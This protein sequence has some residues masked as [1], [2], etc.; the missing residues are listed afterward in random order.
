MRLSA[1]KIRFGSILILVVVS[2][3]GAFARAADNDPPF[4]T[5]TEKQ[6]VLTRILQIV[7][8]SYVDTTITT[9]KLF[10]GAI[11]GAIKT[12]DPHSSYMPPDVADA[13]DEKIRGDFEGI[14]ITFTMLDDTITVIEV[15]E[16]GPSELA[17]L[18]PRDRIVT[19]DGIDVIGVATDSVKVLLRG[20]RASRVTV[21]V[22]RPGVPLELP[23]VIVRDTILLNSVSHAYM[24]DETTGYIAIS[25]F[26]TNTH[27]D[28]EKSL[29]DLS[30]AGMRQLVLDMRNNSGGSLSAAVG[31]VNHFVPGGVI[32][33]TRGK[34]PQDNLVRHADGY[35]AYPDVPMIV[36][37]NHRSA[38]ASEVVAG[39]LQDHDR[40]L[41]VGRTSFGKG[42]VMNSIPLFFEGRDL[43]TLVL[44]VAHYY[45]PSGRLIQRSYEDGRDQYI[46]EGYDDIDPNESDSTSVGEVFYTDLGRKVFG[47]GGITPDVKLG[48][49]PQLNSLEVALRRVNPFFEFADR[50]LNDAEDIPDDFDTFLDTYTIS[51]T[52]L[53]AFMKF[54]E[55][56]KGV[57]VAIEQPFGDDIEALLLR[58]NI[59]PEAIDTIIAA[60]GQSGVS[61]DDAL[62]AQ[63]KDFIAREIKQE[64]ARIVWGPD[65]R[66]R[67]WHTDDVQLLEAMDSFAD[68]G[69]LLR[70]RI[71]LG[72]VQSDPLRTE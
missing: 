68:A 50:Y 66:Y 38:S 49:L 32:V 3:A 56:E 70:E 57:E 6:F 2:A 7:P 48:P 12:L 65:A 14:G 59:E 29:E 19:V 27:E 35:A 25:K 24:I 10:D 18:K 64:I 47:G 15:V 30:A 11:E 58:Y 72:R 28:V 31:V 5:Q 33:R 55:D 41:I 71:S 8:R 63:S 1:N 16:D 23:F 69:E 42:L 36:M 4:L 53:A 26:T 37:I 45:T 40:A 34:R 43:G 61:D 67:V 44:S 60:L 9:E 54:V 39:A 21:G 13:F 62:I 46:R 51:D 52:A 17:G 22:R 20:E